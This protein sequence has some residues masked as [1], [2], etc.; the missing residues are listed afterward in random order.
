M[1]D[2]GCGGECGCGYGPNVVPGPCLIP[3]CHPKKVNP[4]IKIEVLPANAGTDEEGQP[5]APKLGAN[6]NAFV[7]YSANGAIYYYNERGIYL[8]ISPGNCSKVEDTLT[9]V[10]NNQ[11]ELFAPTVEALDVATYEDLTNVNPSD[12]PSGGKVYV[13]KDELHNDESS[14]YYWDTASEKWMYQ[15][16]ASP[17]YT[18]DFLNKAIEN[19]QANINAEV[20]AREAADIAINGQI[21]EINN[22]IEEAITALEAI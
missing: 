19:L 3:K 9:T 10:V 1:K 2:C 11:N 15:G 16:P 20:N 21:A 14:L 8:N 17:Y 6:F 18:R 7:Q 5:F 12:I 13:E 22:K 4:R